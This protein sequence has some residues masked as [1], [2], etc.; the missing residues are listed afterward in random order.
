MHISDGILPIQVSLVADAVV[1]PSVFLL[2]KQINSKEIPKIGVFT[3]ALFVISL[4]HFP[5]G[6]TSI[7]LGRG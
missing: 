1:I 3:A 7:H 4:I 6:T 2:G 5:L